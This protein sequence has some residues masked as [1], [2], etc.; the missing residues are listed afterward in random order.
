MKHVSPRLILCS[1]LCLAGASFAYAADEAAPKK[2]Q[3]PQKELPKE[4]LEAL[5]PEAQEQDPGKISA[6]AFLRMARR[7]PAGESWAKMEGT[8][9]HRRSGSSAIRDSIRVGIRFTPK[10]VIAQLVFAGN[11]YYE[12]GQTF[13]TPP[14][15]TQE[16][17]V[18]D[19]NRTRLSLYGIL[20]SDLTLGFLY[21]DLVREEKPESVKMIDCRVFVL[22]GGEDDYVRVWLS[23]EYFFPLKAHWFRT[24]PD[25]KTRP[26]REL[27]LGGVK[28]ENDFYVV[29][30]LFLFGQDWRTRVEFDKRDAGRVEEAKAPLDLFL[31]R[32]DEKPAAPA[33]AD[34]ADTDKAGDKEPGK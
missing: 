20:P 25:E 13:D 26:Y 24:L 28:K 22:K 9:T 1:L 34:D 29:Q 33:P 3:E 27:E 30:E 6:E 31:S 17:D 23:K 14:V 16:T 7:A 11:E 15:F 2:D 5:F 32:D 21:R 18:P 10:R 19:K 8:A 4:V 12:M